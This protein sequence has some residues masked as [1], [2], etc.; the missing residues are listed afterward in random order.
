ML[1]EFSFAGMLFSPMV[2]FVPIAFLLYWLTQ[3]LMHKFNLRQWIWKPAWFDL[4]MLV[5]YIGLVV[6]IGGR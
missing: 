3:W 6:W 1:H 2:V 4:S 5:C